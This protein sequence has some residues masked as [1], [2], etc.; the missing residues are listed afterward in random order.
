MFLFIV[1]FR[2]RFV[3]FGDLDVIGIR[4][5]IFN[6]DIVS[7]KF[8]D[9]GFDGMWILGIFCFFFSLLCKLKKKRKNWEFKIVFIESE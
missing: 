9:I 1:W 3:L 6:C 8:F 5:W 4:L 2:L 7:L